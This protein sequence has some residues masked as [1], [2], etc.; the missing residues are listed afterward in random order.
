MKV[1]VI[2]QKLDNCGQIVDVVLNKYLGKYT[3]GVKTYPKAS[4]SF[5]AVEEDDV[6]QEDKELKEYAF[7]IL[8]AKE[9][10][11]VEKGSK[12]D[13]SAEIDYA[14]GVAKFFQIAANSVIENEK[15]SRKVEKS[16]QAQA[17]S[18]GN[19]PLPSESVPP[20]ET[21]A[22]NEKPADVPKDESEIGLNDLISE[23]N[24]E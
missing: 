4:L 7:R 2:D 14:F 24:N 11:T 15:E 13:I 19:A 6:C 12:D 21:E 16:V 17:V 3:D 20:K 10:A 18:S 5:D 1:K 8:C 9:S 23:L 22:E